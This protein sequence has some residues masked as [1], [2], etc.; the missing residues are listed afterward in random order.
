MPLLPTAARQAYTVSTRLVLLDEVEPAFLRD[1]ARPKD[2]YVFSAGDLY[3]GTKQLFHTMKRA[4]NELAIADE[5][6]DKT[7][8]DYIELQQLPRPIELHSSKNDTFAPY[9]A[10]T[11]FWRWAT[12]RSGYTLT[13]SSPLAVRMR[14][15]TRPSPA[16]EATVAS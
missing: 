1:A 12:R 13:P 2:Q 7:V 6:L 9:D 3:T 10:C 8:F 11:A 15:D 14:T 5:C 16:M 4:K